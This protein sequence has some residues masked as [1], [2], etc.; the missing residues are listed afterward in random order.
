MF[1]VSM[2]GLAGLWGV[3]GGL[4]PQCLRRKRLLRV[5]WGSKRRFE[6]IWTDVSCIFDYTFSFNLDIRK[7]FEHI[8]LWAGLVYVDHLAVHHLFTCVSFW[9]KPK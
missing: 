3:A 7:L 5:S 1:Q 4:N 8:V 2:R 9:L 6:G